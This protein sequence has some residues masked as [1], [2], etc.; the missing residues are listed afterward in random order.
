MT[1]NGVK[2]SNGGRRRQREIHQGMSPAT[3]PGARM[4]K[5]AVPR[6]ANLRPV[7]LPFSPAMPS[8]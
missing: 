8:G 1:R 2:P 6:M 7:L 3:V 5:T 4:R